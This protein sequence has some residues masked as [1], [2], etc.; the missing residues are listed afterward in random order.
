MRL[1]A[2]ATSIIT[3]WNLEVTGLTIADL[4]ASY[5]R[6]GAAAVKNDL[7][8]HGAV[9]DAWD[10]NEAIEVDSANCPGLYRV[11][12]PDAAFAAGADRVQLCVHDGASGTIAPQFIE[13]ELGPVPADTIQISGGATEADRLQAAL[14][15]GDYIAADVIRINGMVAA[16]EAFAGMFGYAADGFV[17]ADTTASTT[18]AERGTALTD[19]YDLA[20]DLTPGGN[21]L[22]EDNRA[23][24]LIPPGSYQLVATLDLDTEFVDLL[25]LVPEKGGE[26]EST[27]VDNSASGVSLDQFRPPR[28]LIY[29]DDAG[30]TT[31]DQSVANVW[32][33]GFGIAQLSDA[34]DSYVRAFYCSA[35]DNA[36][37]RYDKMYFWRRRL[38]QGCSAVSFAK[39]VRGVWR[40]CIA[41]AYSWRSGSALGEFSA[42]MYDC[43]AGAYSFIGDTAP[44]VGCLFVRCRAIGCFAGSF[45]DSGL[46]AFGG[47]NTYGSDLDGDCRFVECEAGPRS[48]GLGKKNEATFIRCRGGDYSFGSTVSLFITGEFGGYA[49]DC[50]GG[51]GSFGGRGT[52]ATGAGKLTGTL[53]RCIS[54]GAKMPWQLEGATVEDSLLTVGTNDQ[55]CITLLDSLSRIHNS[56][57]LVVEGGT[58][59]PI[60]AASALTVSA[61]GNRYNNKD[62]TIT[63][64]GANV[65]NQGIGDTKSTMGT[66][67]EAA[68]ATG[69]ADERLKTLDDAYT[70][71]R[72]PY[73]DELA[74]ANLPSDVDEILEDTATTLPAAIA[75]EATPVNIVTEA[76][77]ISSD[78]E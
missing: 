61:A 77:N 62:Q 78:N 32:M 2:G 27:D 7:I 48:Y 23:A 31:V 6:D 1:P 22:A 13:V 42:K 76:R 15:T 44:G 37:S 36:G 67:I 49:E 52:A 5:V 55:D 71:A 9:T 33:C 41:N 58:G 72:A 3:Y 29:T 38:A 46:G 43:C 4:D 8:A 20:V 17:V 45:S 16:A 35:D 68:P 21:A 57:L 69:S 63:G 34:A 75:A 19:A 25:A 39:H 73:L 54:E 47:C 24:V 12:F 66:V 28:T 74:A 60:D 11:D 10:D 26:P 18:D 65:T 64:L 51:V 56:T 14:G 53:V 59:V 30:V 70:A 50:V 40:D